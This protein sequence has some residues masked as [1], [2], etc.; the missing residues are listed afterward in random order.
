MENNEDRYITWELS[1]VSAIYRTQPKAY[2]YGSKFGLD[3]AFLTENLSL[4]PNLTLTKGIEEEEVW[5]GLP[6]RHVGAHHWGFSHDMEE[7]QK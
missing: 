6:G 5:N 2:V 3:V 1:N 4:I 7:Y